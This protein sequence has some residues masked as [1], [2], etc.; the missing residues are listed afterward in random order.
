MRLLQPVNPLNYFHHFQPFLRIGR[1]RAALPQ[2][3]NY[4]FDDV[5]VIGG[6][7][8]VGTVV[9]G[10]VGGRQRGHHVVA[11]VAIFHLVHVLPPDFEAAVLGHHREGAFQ[12]LVPDGGAVAERAAA[13]A[14]E[15]EGDEATVFKFR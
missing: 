10:G 3:V 4:V 15:V 2:G 8:L 7:A 5:A 13:A 9:V 11:Q 1:G 12:I 6:R 14:H